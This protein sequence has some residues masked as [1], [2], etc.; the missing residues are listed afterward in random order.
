V[1][2][3]ENVRIIVVVVDF[4]YPKEHPIRL[5]TLADALECLW[6]IVDPM[7]RQG[8]ENQIVRAWAQG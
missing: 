2:Q 6:Q 1:W 8:A 3:F 7:K 5:E 4:S